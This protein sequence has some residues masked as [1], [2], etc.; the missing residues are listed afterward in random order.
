M[1]PQLKADFGIDA[2]IEVVHDTRPTGR[3]VAAQIKGGPSYVGPKRQTKDGFVFYIDPAHYAY[4]TNF[5]LPVVI[6]LVDVDK[7]EAWW[8]RVALETVEKTET[9][10]KIIVPHEQKLDAAA[11]EAFAAIGDSPEPVKRFTELTLARPWMEAINEGKRLFVELEEWVN[12][13]SGRGAL[14]LVVQDDEA[15]EHALTWPVIFLGSTSFEQAVRDFFP[16]AD[17]DVDEELYDEREEERWIEDNGMWDAEEGV[18]LYDHTHLAEHMELRR[19]YAEY[20]EVGPYEEDGEVAKY[21]L[22]LMLNEIGRGF[23]AVAEYLYEAKPA[24]RAATPQ[25]APQRSPA[26]R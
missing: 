13:S 19:E 8:Q 22:E 18:Y 9:Q 5:S 2:H 24:V 23:L 25:V 6:I 26:G 11:I 21:R 4:W 12:K 16:W 10:W 7:Q 3:L 14:R 1:R 20:A 17:V 15:E